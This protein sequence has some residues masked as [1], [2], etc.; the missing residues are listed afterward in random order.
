MLAD[1]EHLIELQQVDL[2]LQELTRRIDLFPDRRQQA[3][4]QLTA[5]RRRLDEARS[6][7]AESVKARKTLEL[8]VKQLEEKI[9]K[10]KSQVYEVK[11]NEAYRA[12]QEEIQG[13]ERKKAEVEDRELEGM[14]AAEELEKE[15][16]AGEAELARVEQQVK[17]ALRQLDQ[18]QDACEKEAAD[19]QRQREALRPQVSEETL[20]VYDR[21]A[22][23]HGGIAL[24]EAREEVC[25]VCRVRIRPQTFVE[26]KRNDRIHFCD[27]CH[28]ILYFRRDPPA[29]HPA[30][31]MR[32]KPVAV[33]ARP[34]RADD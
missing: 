20:S 10:H 27:S 26:V 21:I 4:Q 9:S 23:A 17:A 2:R 6:R 32:D 15:I 29:E 14:L 8:D 24:A 11:S 19:L 13:E 25:Q 30:D 16:K 18:E 28:R 1:L 31:A 22:R 12:L 3:E 7:H 5:I 33:Q 34:E